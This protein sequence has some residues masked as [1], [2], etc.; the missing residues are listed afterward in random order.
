[1]LRILG[2]IA[3]NLVILMKSYYFF[4]KNVPNFTFFSAEGG[5]QPPNSPSFD[6]PAKRYSGYGYIAAY[7]NLKEFV[8]H[9]ITSLS[10][11]L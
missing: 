5:L 8:A 4:P 2:K 9:I 10:Y 7:F 11:Y 3:P 6:A 1:M